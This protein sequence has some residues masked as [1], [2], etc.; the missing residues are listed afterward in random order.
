[1]IC[2]LLFAEEMEVEF[3]REKHTM[4]ERSSHVRDRIRVPRGSGIL[5]QNK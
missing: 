1:M 5:C 2:N 3:R 4:C